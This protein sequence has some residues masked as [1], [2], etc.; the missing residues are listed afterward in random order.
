MKKILESFKNFLTE[1]SLIDYDD[2]GVMTLYHYSKSPE[3]ELVLD[4]DFFISNTST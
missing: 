2:Q 4:P 1:G 3:E